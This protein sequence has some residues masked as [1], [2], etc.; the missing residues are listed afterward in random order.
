ME[1]KQH[2][3][4]IFE[5]KNKSKKEKTTEI[6]KKKI[7]GKNYFD[8]GHNNEFSETIPSDISNKSKNK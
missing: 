1:I 6:K 2:I 5:S 8:T 7:Y 3:L 4:N